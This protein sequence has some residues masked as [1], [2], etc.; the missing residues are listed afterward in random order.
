MLRSKKEQPRLELDLGKAQFRVEQRPRR[1]DVYERAA[2]QGA[3]ILPA[4]EVMSG[5]NEMQF[6]AEFTLCR[7]L[8][9]F[10]DGFA[11]VALGLTIAARLSAPTS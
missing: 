3:R 6:V 4:M 5:G 7:S 2:R 8:K 1:I 9:A 10:D 11:I